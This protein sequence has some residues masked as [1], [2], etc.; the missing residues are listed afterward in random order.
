MIFR[1]AFAAHIAWPVERPFFPEEARQPDVGSS[2]AVGN[3]DEDMG[4]GSEK[5]RTTDKRKNGLKS[6]PKLC[7]LYFK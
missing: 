6:S 4:Q 5:S 1:E 7:E 3:G 2:G